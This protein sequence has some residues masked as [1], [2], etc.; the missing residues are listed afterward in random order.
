M[1]MAEFAEKYQAD[2][3]PI[4]KIQNEWKRREIEADLDLLAAAGIITADGAIGDGLSDRISSELY[5]GLNKLMK[6]VDSY[7]DARAHLREILERGDSSILGFINKIKGQIGE[8]RFLDAADGYA[9]LATSGSQEGWDI[10]VNDGNITHY[11]QVKMYSNPLDVIRKM[12][13]VQEKVDHGIIFDGSEQVTHIDFAVPHDIIEQ[14]KELASRVPEL[15]DIELIPVS[16]TAA[17]A[18]NVVSDGLEN[19]GPDALGHLFGEL[20]HGALNA[21]AMHAMISAVLVWRKQMAIDEA[22]ANVLGNTAISAAAYAGGLAIEVLLDS[23]LDAL[24]APVSIGA[25]IAI[26]VALKKIAKGRMNAYQQFL[27]NKQIM[28]NRIAMLHGLAA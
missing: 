4:A 18:A 26:R 6:E 3:K 2:S 11:V 21:A 7:G 16:M 15:A 10:A 13:E 1:N 27:L 25:G 19:L 5:N 20:M 17:E 28:N 24:L 12:T 23:T 22:A 9:R 14:V 8:N